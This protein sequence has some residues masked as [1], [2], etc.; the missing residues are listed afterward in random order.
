MFGVIDPYLEYRP[1]TQTRLFRVRFF[2]A[3]HILEGAMLLCVTGWSLIWA[4][5]LSLVDLPMWIP[6]ACFYAGLAV[7]PFSRGRN[8]P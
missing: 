2:L 8:A 3:G 1:S 4:V 5:A 7:I 6:V